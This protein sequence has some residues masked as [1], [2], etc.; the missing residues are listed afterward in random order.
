VER[1]RCEDAR[2][3]VV[4]LGSMCGTAR[5][6]IDQLRAD[7]LAAGLL[8]LRLFRPLPQQ[9]LRVALAG[10]PDVLV[11][12]R[13]HSP[14]LGGIL[15]RKV[16]AALYGLPDAPRVHGVLAGV[17]GVDVRA[18]AHPRA[19]GCG[20]AGCGRARIDLGVTM[21]RIERRDPMLCSGH[22]ACPGCMEAL[23][24]RHVLARMGPDTMAVIPPSCMAIIAGPQPYSSLRIP[25]YQPDAGSERR[26]RIRA[27]AGARCAGPQRHAGGGAG[28]R[29]RHLRHRPCSACHRRRSATRTCCYSAWTTRAT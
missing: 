18:A 11:L 14:G 8:K 20:I 9:A 5:E 4:A 7:G 1:Y 22:A 19:G 23:S 26:R 3:V 21:E 2:I 17:G 13:N 25:V 28:R 16:R 10:V 15:H 24:A 27:A 12:D 29:W 6:A